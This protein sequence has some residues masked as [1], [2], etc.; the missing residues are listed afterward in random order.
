M[1]IE[2]SVMGQKKIVLFLVE[3]KSD[4]V[5][6]GSIMKRLY[7]EHKV[8]F[9]YIRTDITSDDNVL[10]KEIEDKVFEIVEQYRERNSLEKDDIVKVIQLSDTDGAFVNAK[11]IKE[12]ECGKTIYYE[13]WIEAKDKSRLIARNMKKTQKINILRKIER[14]KEIYDYN[15]FFMSRNLEH[16]LFDKCEELSDD[17]K[18]D[19]SDS[20]AEKYKGKEE[21]FI[22][23]IGNEDIA[24]SG[25]YNQ[26]WK[27][28]QEKN[29][30][31]K[32][33]SN[34]H[35]LFQIMVPDEEL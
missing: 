15:I 30:S 5:A 6:L 29:H 20:F 4:D 14:L 22:S 7:N 11:Y 13:E 9:R 21:E 19:L 28:I 17:E 10:V 1:T 31:L 25:D 27:Y 2:D 12:S 26:S 16:V 33:G 18:E 34:L 32:R 8:R 35:L 24:V 3:G 23:F